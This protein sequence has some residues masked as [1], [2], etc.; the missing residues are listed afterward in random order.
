MVVNNWFIVV[1]MYT[2]IMDGDTIGSSKTY[3]RLYFISF[4]IVVVLM[5]LN[6]LVAVVLEIYGSVAGNM[7]EKR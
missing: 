2:A 1:D 3:V 5:Q 4:W 6:L 7:R